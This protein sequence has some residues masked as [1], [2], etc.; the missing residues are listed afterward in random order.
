MSKLDR[1]GWAGGVAFAA[2]AA[3][4]GVR[5]SQAEALDRLS[6]HLPPAK[7]LSLRQNGAAVPPGGPAG[8]EALNPPGRLVPHQAT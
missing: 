4:L 7:P 5:V 3:P 1:L 6:P 8:G 2:F